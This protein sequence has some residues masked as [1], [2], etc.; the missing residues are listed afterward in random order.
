[1][2][3]ERI[4]GNTFGMHTSVGVL[5]LNTFPHINM[6]KEIVFMFFVLGLSMAEVVEFT[7]VYSNPRK[8]VKEDIIEQR[9]E[10]RLKCLNYAAFQGCFEYKPNQVIYQ[11]S[12]RLHLKYQDDAEE[13][14]GDEDR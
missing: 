8:I 6:I 2:V 5:Q 1:M 11:L 9:Y 14:D 12:K 13:D 10:I 4:G 3:I 7:K